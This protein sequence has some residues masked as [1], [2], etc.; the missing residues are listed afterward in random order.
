MPKDPTDFATDVFELMLRNGT[1]SITMTWPEF[2]ERADLQRFREERG[3]AISEACK[4]LG[5]VV[6][7][8][9][10]AVIFS[11]DANFSPVAK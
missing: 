6:G 7:Y 3:E 5:L 2:Y 4:S 9:I 8:G 11:R 1:P 10:H